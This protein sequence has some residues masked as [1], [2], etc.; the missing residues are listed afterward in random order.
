MRNHGTVATY[1]CHH[2][3][4]S[5]DSSLNAGGR[6]RLLTCS[7]KRSPQPSH[8]MPP[9]RPRAGPLT[10]ESDNLQAVVMGAAKADVS[11]QIL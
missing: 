8:S 7:M 4:P 9:R 10:G 6:L 11:L 1:S 2:R 5:S 3:Y